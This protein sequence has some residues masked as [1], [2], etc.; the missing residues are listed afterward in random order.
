MPKRFN[1]GDVS[2]TLSKCE[3]YVEYPNG[4]FAPVRTR[5]RDRY[6]VNVITKANGCP[7]RTEKLFLDRQ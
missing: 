3:K 2:V 6:F 1:Y 7:Q 4:R 5:G